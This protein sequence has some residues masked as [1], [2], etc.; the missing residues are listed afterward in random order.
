MTR[1]GTPVTVVEGPFEGTPAIF[2]R[3]AGAKVVV[4]LTVFGRTTEV[5]LEREQVVIGAPS[6]EE[7]EA[8]VTAAVRSRELPQ[9]LYSFWRREVRARPTP[10]GDDELAPIATRFEA[11]EA[12]QLRAHEAR[13]A[14]ELARLREAFAG[15]DDDARARKWVAERARWVEWRT[16]AKE[17]MA[18]LEAELPTPPLSSPEF[19][20]RADAEHSLRMRVEGFRARE[21]L[22]APLE[23]EQRNAELEAAIDADPDADAA[24]LVYGD[25][26]EARGEPRGELVS[27]HAAGKRAPQL[28]QR[29]LGGL[30]SFERLEPRWRLGFLEAV[31]VEA[32]RADEG[33]GVNLARLVD[34]LWA[35]PSARFVRELTIACAS[36]HEDG[37]MSR[38][39]DTLLRGG[40]RPSLRR[41]VFDTNT[42]EEMLSWTSTGELSGLSAVFP[43]L[44]ALFV[45]A[46]SVELSRPDF[47]RLRA[48]DLRTPSMSAG[49]LQQ[50]AAAAWPELRHLG[51][52]FGSR[53]YGVEVT[54]DEV[55]ALLDAQGMPR[56]ESLALANTELSDE[57]CALLCTHPLLARL[58]RLDLSM[59]TM[60]EAGA[61]TLVAHRERLRHLEVLDVDD[62]YLPADALAALKNALPQVNSREQRVPESSDGQLYRYAAVGE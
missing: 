32:T 1:P 59:G 11:W 12:E 51:L 53:S 35:L 36:A 13:V 31:R 54:V 2:V 6:M 21:A 23:H 15:L 44:E 38:V 45:H 60:S 27:L 47:P 46:G 55:R 5:T 7:L 62:N 9:R 28:E 3:E 61:A 33:D 25:W 24:F 19:D 52:W 50:L 57:L 14:A 39:L 10:P 16:R 8:Q 37:V 56:L 40:P 48:L 30:A 17:V 34:K 20:A 29:L 4:E 49:L 18:E 43:R 26:L 22:R 58:K 42:E 41:L